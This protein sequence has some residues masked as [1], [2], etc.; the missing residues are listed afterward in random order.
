MLFSLYGPPEISMSRS[1]CSA[2]VIM[3]LRASGLRLWQLYYK[4]RMNA[5]TCMNPKLCLRKGRK[6]RGEY[7]Q[8]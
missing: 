4:I 8:N 7:D 2:G 5:V 3:S 1:V 6:G